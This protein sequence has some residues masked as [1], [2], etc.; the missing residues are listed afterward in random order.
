MKN[1]YVSIDVEFQD[2]HGN[3][4]VAEVQGR[5][6][7]GRAFDIEVRIDGNDITDLVHTDEYATL[8]EVESVCNVAD[9]E[10]ERYRDSKND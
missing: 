3:I 10:F 6:E 4:L 7:D 8:L 5:V 1:N 2:S 9:R